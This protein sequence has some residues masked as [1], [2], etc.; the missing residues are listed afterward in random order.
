M[1]SLQLP[2]PE[3]SGIG[4]QV[5]DEVHRPRPHLPSVVFIRIDGVFEEDVHFLTSYHGFAIVDGHSHVQKRHKVQFF[6][7]DQSIE[8]LG[9]MGVFVDRENHLPVH[10]LQIRPEGVQR[11]VVFVVSSHHLF[12]L[13][14]RF[15]A[16][17]ALVETKT[18]ERRNVP[19][20]DI[21]VI[22]L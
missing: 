3:K 13:R 15:I 16:P 12:N 11:N 14:E 4:M 7:F 1:Q 22:F 9:R 5:V 6:I 17:T 20:A 18:P 19:P 21:F 8:L 10:V 2:L